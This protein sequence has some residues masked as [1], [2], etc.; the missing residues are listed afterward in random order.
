M[1][2]K[3]ILKWILKEIRLEE[4]DW[5]HLAQ[6]VVQWWALGKGII[7]L[8]VP[9]QVGNLSGSDDYWFLQH[10]CATLI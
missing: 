3:I 5:V 10:F 8:Q 7:E 1:E 9:L 4:V 2:G 6:D